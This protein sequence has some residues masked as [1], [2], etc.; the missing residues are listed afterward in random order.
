VTRHALSHRLLQA[1]LGHRSTNNTAP[2]APDQ[3]EG[4]RRQDK[5]R[6]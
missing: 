2:L 3:F 1:W 4:F 6:N 5:H